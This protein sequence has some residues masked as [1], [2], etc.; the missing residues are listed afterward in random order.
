[1]GAMNQL[2]HKFTIFLLCDTLFMKVGCDKYV[3]TP[4]SIAYLYDSN[5][6]SQVPVCN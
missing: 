1:M 3:V 4:S 6:Y 5:K 2:S